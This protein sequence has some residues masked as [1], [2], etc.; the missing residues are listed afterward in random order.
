V[1]R[2]RGLVDRLTEGVKED[3][4]E[5]ATEGQEVDVSF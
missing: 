3:G 1:L 4:L 5:E 2:D